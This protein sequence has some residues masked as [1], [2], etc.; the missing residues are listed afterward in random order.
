MDVEPTILGPDSHGQP[1]SCVADIHPRDSPKGGQQPTGAEAQI[2]H[3]R[4]RD[5]FLRDPRCHQLSSMAEFWRA[6]RH[7]LRPRRLGPTTDPEIKRQHGLHEWRRILHARRQGRSITR[8]PHEWLSWQR[9]S[10]LSHNMKNGHPS[11]RWSLLATLPSYVGLLRVFLWFLCDALGAFGAAL[12]EFASGLAS[13]FAI[14][15]RI[16]TR[17]IRLSVYRRSDFFV[18]CASRH[19]SVQLLR[20]RNQP[21]DDIF[22]MTPSRK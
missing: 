7:H 14:V 19:A 5:A 13:C 17:V 4:H 8:L 6:S 10:G 11:P 16:S 20:S 2:H 22:W 1:D 3:L 21:I 18:V 12:A 15:H 9:E